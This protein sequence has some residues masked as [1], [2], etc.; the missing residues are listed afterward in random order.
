MLSDLIFKNSSQKELGLLKSTVAKIN[1]LEAQIKEVPNEKFATKTLEFKSKINNGMRLDDLIPETFAY[2]REA[3]RRSL[4]ERHFDVQLMGGIVLHQGKISEMKTGEGKTLV[5]TLP[6]ALNALTGRG[7][8][9][10][11]VNEYLAERDS[12]WMGHLFNFLGITVGCIFNQ[13][14]RDKKVEA[15]QRDITYGVNSRFC[16]DYLEDNMAY[17]ASEQVQRNHVFAIIDEVDSVLVDEARTPMILSGQADY[18]SS[19]QRFNDFV[20]HITAVLHST[21]QL[22]LHTSPRPR[23]ASWTRP[24]KRTTGEGEQLIL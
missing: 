18:S 23:L 22:R 1:S 7:A 3:A 4:G 12:Q 2:V 17:S 6:L 13:M 24:H 21:N 5:S 19:N 15:Y 20:S 9:V 14:P 10:V 11:T 16:F 8:H